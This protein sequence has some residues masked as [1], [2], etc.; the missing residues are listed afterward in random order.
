M[1]PTGA[2]WAGHPCHE[3]PGVNTSGVDMARLVQSCPNACADV[4]PFCLPPSPPP[5][6][7]PSWPPRPY[8]PPHPP[9]PSPPP[10]LAWCL[11]YSFEQSPGAVVAVVLLMLALLVAAGLVVRC[12]V[13]RLGKPF[14]PA[15]KRRFTGVTTWLVRRPAC[16]PWPLRKS[17]AL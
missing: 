6:P 10:D 13:P 7:P 17:V 8:W 16:R 4:V 12:M 15:K 9:P 2:D 5:P 3:A 1:Q 14:F 11:D